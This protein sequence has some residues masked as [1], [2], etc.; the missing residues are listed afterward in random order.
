MDLCTR[1]IH[2]H[3]TSQ[4]RNSTHRLALVGADSNSATH[5]PAP[6]TIP[7]SDSPADHLSQ[8]GG[9]DYA[10]TTCLP[11]WLGTVSTLEDSPPLPYRDFSDVFEKR[12]ADRL[13]EHRPYDCP[14]DLQ[15][16]MCS[17]F[18]PMYGL[19]K[20]ELEAFQTYL[21]ESLDKGFML[22]SKSPVDAPILFVKKTKTSK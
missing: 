15:E 6:E 10:L 9:D 3:P 22:P 8:T 21:D 14:I 7:N 19:S 20:L 5:S 16:G 2:F 17:P 1:S 13:P 18:G 12:N 4:P 11:P